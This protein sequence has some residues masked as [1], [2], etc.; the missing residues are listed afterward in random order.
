M[1]LD[2]I[3]EV[4]FRGTEFSFFLQLIEDKNYLI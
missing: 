2:N 3:P 1:H 4:E